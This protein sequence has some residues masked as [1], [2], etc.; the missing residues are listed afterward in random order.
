MYSVDTIISSTTLIIAETLTD[1]QNAVNLI[2]NT[3][4]PSS[5][6]VSSLTGFES[7]SNQEVDCFSIPIVNTQ[8]VTESHSL[9]SIQPFQNYQWTKGIF[10]NL[11]FFIYEFKRDYETVKRSIEINDGKVV[12]SMDQASFIVCPRT[13]DSDIFKDD[14]AVSA[15]WL[16]TCLEAKRLVSR[17]SVVLYRPFPRLLKDKTLCL[18]G[19]GVDD[20]YKME[21]Y[22]V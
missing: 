4:N 10:S 19:F 9:Y 18:T 20:R 22:I 16:K 21:N 6:N 13:V 3:E 12:T 1:Y 14:R 7:T 8:W 5:S 17:S 11:S 15:K 2:H